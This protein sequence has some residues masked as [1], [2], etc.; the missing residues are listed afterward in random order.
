[1]VRKNTSMLNK[2]RKK[3]GQKP[4]SSASS[5]ETI[6]FVGRSWF[7]PL[8]LVVFSLLFLLT[9]YDLY[10]GDLV[11]WVTGALYFL[12]GVFW[13][14]VRRPFLGIGRNQLTTRRWNGDQTIRPDEIDQI[15]LVPGAIIIQLKAK[16]QRWVFSQFMQRFNPDEIWPHLRDFAA[17]HRIPANENLK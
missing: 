10:N 6:R 7:F 5:D 16:K 17:R 1:M 3:L 12:L 13:Y 2:Q 4:I 8:L 9:T 11:Y 14:F 15:S